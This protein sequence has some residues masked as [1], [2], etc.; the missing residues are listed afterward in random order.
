MC[1]LDRGKRTRRHCGGM[2]KERNVLKGRDWQKKCEILKGM[3]RAGRSNGRLGVRQR[4]R[5]SVGW[6][7]VKLDSFAYSFSDF[8]GIKLISCTMKL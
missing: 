6:L 2:K 3:K 1:L 4:K 5:L 7:Y 8:R